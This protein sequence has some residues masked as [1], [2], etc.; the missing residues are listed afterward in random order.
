[1][2]DL[3]WHVVKAKQKGRWSLGGGV[4]ATREG[5]GVGKEVLRR[6]ERE[7]EGGGVVAATRGDVAADGD[8]GQWEAGRKGDRGYA[9]YGGE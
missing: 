4:A 6:P 5:G 9:P 3:E 7:V 8:S 1:M 2:S